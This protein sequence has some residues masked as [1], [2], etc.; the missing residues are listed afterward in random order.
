MQT[1]LWGIANKAAKDKKYRFRNLFGMLTVVFLHQCWP[2][3][4]KKSSRGVDKVN[5]K[6]YEENL[7]SNIE[8]LVERVKKLSYRA[9]LI[10]R[11]FIPKIGGKQRPLGIPATEDK[12]LQM[13]VAKIL[14]AIFES[15]FLTCCFGYRPKLSAH[16]AIKDISYNLF[17]GYNG[18][19]YIVEAD[20][21][22]FFDNISHDWML[23]M[24]EL[25]IEDRPFLNLIRKWLKAGILVEGK[26]ID[27]AT[28]TPQGGIISPILA[29]IYL[30]YVL[31]IWFEHIVKEAMFGRAYLCRYADDFICAFQSQRDAE[32]FYKMLQ[33]RM[34]KF[35]LELAK[36]K[37]RVM[38]FS[39]FFFK[40][41]HTSFD[42]LGFEF[43]WE[44]S[45]TGRD[46]LSKRTSREK[47]RNTFVKFKEWCKKSR[48]RKI[49]DLMSE[50]N[51][52][53]RGYY[54][55]YGIIGNSKS[56][57]EFFYYANRILFKWLNRRSQRKSF[58]WSKFNKML[59]Y[60]NIL[61]PRITQR[62][63]VQLSMTF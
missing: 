33:E 22:G 53:L 26:V 17:N 21:R 6:E 47:L 49:R 32:L 12:L 31:D 36:E 58:N 54:N 8:S 18:Y 44:T 13:G 10:L 19:N 48:N 14:E 43:R 61:K 15:I 42:F 2:F 50:L 39:R 62:H 45:R 59:K 1:S 7:H 52:K 20:I 40:E 16:D 5:A 38:R 46:K 28:G 56:L 57:S 11:R 34:A 51:T 4:N 37:T 24:L 3:I 55:Y 63:E 41:D 9:K 23:K 35:G 29:N 27:P 25:H 60:Y 30:H